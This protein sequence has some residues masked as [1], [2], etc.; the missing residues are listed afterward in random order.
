M[1]GAFVVRLA[2][3]RAESGGDLREWR[4]QP[5]RMT[6]AWRH[7]PKPGHDATQPSSDDAACAPDTGPPLSP[8]SATC[9]SRVPKRASSRTAA[10]QPST[11]TPLSSATICGACQTRASSAH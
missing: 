3:A 6:C 9:T 10:V 5:S 1:A 11:C 8:A 4:E 7:A 2:V